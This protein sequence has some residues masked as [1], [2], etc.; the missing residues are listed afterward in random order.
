MR[1]ILDTTHSDSE[2]ASVTA[3]I[4]PVDKAKLETAIKTA[5]TYYD[6]IKDNPLFASVAETL[7]KA[8]DAAKAAVENGNVTAS[9]VEAQIA[10][11]DTA[12]DTAKKEA[13]EVLWSILS[14]TTEIEVECQSAPSQNIIPKISALTTARSCGDF[15]FMAQCIRVAPTSR[16]GRN[17]ISK[18]TW[19]IIR[20][21]SE[22]PR[23]CGHPDGS[24][25]FQQ[26][27]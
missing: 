8:I 17:R 10:A 18:A 11:V 23:L 13:E 16:N 20:N 7:K 21:E 5:E 24:G 25:L 6:S 26:P 19:R 12:V 4:N 3:T 1:K 2:A 9:E 14:G 15:S 22:N 27:R